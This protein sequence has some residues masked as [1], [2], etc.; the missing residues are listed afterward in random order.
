MGNNEAPKRVRCATSLLAIGDRSGVQVLSVAVRCCGVAVLRC[1][2]CGCRLPA[3]RSVD[4]KGSR[5]NGT[6]AGC[7]CGPCHAGTAHSTP[8]PCTRPNHPHDVY[9][10][11]YVDRPHDV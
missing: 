1:T 10:S 7:T 11:S 9:S 6:T 4:G 2:C 8:H 5:K 3:S